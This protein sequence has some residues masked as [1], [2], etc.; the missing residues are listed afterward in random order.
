MYMPWIAPIGA[1]GQPEPF[2][3]R[4]MSDESGNPL[5]LQ[6]EV[7]T[8]GQA[9]ACLAAGSVAQ[10][11][12]GTVNTAPVVSPWTDYGIPPSSGVPWRTKGRGSGYASSGESP[13]SDALEG[14][15]PCCCGSGGSVLNMVQAHPWVT[16]GVVLAVVL[17][18]QGADR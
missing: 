8:A 10:P 5:P 11:T 14:R 16:L 2:V 9:V 15:P 7:P 1:G 4:I 13:W 3:P 17:L 12:I 18:F 6:P